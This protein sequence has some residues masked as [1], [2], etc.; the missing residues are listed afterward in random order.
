[1]SDLLERLSTIKQSSQFELQA[2]WSLTNGVL[3]N[4]FIEFIYIITYVSQRLMQRLFRTAAYCIWKIVKDFHYSINKNAA[5]RNLLFLAA[6]SL[7]KKI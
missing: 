4:C 5:A 3:D 6:A 1:M 7:Q 2:N